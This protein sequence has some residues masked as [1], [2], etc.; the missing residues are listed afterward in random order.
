[1][2]KKR[3]VYVILHQHHRRGPDQLVIKYSWDICAFLRHNLC[4][5]G[6]QLEIY[7][8]TNGKVTG[9]RHS[10]GNECVEPKVPMAFAVTHGKGSNAVQRAINMRPGGGQHCST[11][12]PK[13]NPLSTAHFRHNCRKEE[14]CCGTAKKCIFKEWQQNLANRRPWSIWPSEQTFIGEMPIGFLSIWFSRV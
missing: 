12:A 14:N 8:S 1:M 13:R 3:F 6:S 11:V 5:R 9:E 7:Q 2:K 4:M 10:S